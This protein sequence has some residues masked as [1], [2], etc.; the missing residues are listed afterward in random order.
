M[1][2]YK[3]NKKI[4][5]EVLIREIININELIKDKEFEDIYKKI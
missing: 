5:I 2:K 3:F 1:N 4:I